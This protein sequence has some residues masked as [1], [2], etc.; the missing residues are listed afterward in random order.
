MIKKIWLYIVNTWWNFFY[1]ELSEAQV[2]EFYDKFSNYFELSAYLKAN[3]YEWGS[4]GMNILPYYKADSFE[5]PGQVLARKFANCSG[6]MRMFSSFIRYKKCA[7]KVEE[8]LLH[9]GAIGD[10]HYVCMI[11]D[12]GVVYLQSNMNVSVLDKPLLEYYKD[13]YHFQELIDTWEK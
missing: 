9:N 11:Q 13:K 3:G 5:R 2:H 4:D 10:Y 12:R 8:C 7:D 6:W 1:E